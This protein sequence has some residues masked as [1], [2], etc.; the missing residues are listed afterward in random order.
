MVAV[1][2]LS[3][4]LLAILGTLPSSAL[5]SRMAEEEELARNALQDK[6]AEIRAFARDVNAARGIAN[7]RTYKG[8]SFPVE[9]LRFDS[10]G[11]KTF[12]SNDSAPGL[13]DVTD[14][15][16]DRSPTDSAT[17][18]ADRR[19]DLVTIRVR[20]HSNPKDAS[21]REIEFACVLAR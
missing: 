14:Y 11:D 20:W 2:I 10:S 13:V 1:A 8:H 3:I 12:D 19:A 18:A 17:P 16:T 15:P 7:V 21:P 4:A 9:G 6:L 5:V